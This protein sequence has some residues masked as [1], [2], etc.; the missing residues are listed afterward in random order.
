MLVSTTSTPS[1]L[2]AP[3]AS[4]VSKPDQINS[5][6]DLLLH[7]AETIPNTPLIAYPASEHSSSDLAEYTAKD[8]DAFV[9]EAAKEYTRLGLLPKESRSTA[10]EVVALLGPSNLDYVI[11]LLALSRMGF[12]VLFLST[13]LPTEAY[14]SLLQKTSCTKIVASP[15]FAS[16]IVE[17]I[18]G[19]GGY[20]ISSFPQ[21]DKSVYGRR[22]SSSARF[23]RRTEL[24][25]EE[26]CISFIVHSSGSTGL[27]KPIYQTHR[28]CLS[29]Y[30]LGSGMRAFVT[31]PLF[32]NHGLATTFRGIVSGK[33]TVLFNAN[34]PLTNAHLVDAMRAADAESFHCVPYALKVLAESEE[35]IEQLRRCRLVLFGGSSCPDELGD[36][37]V[38]RGVYIVGHYGATEMGQ[39]MT[40]FR[41]PESDKAWNYVR[42]LPKVAPYLRFVDIGAGVYECVVLD[43]LPSKVISNSDEPWPNC[44]RT[45]DTFVPHPTIPDAWK[46]LGR[47]DDRV[48]L[49]NGEKVLPIPYEHQIRQ[50]ELVQDALV[51]G[52]GRAFPGL[53]VIPSEKAAGMSKEEL[54]DALTPAIKTANARAEKFGQV[55]REMVEILPLGTDYPRTDKGTMI[56][57]ACYKKFDELI[58]SVYARF[59]SGEGIT[60]RKLDAEGLRT[61]LADLFA[62]RVGIAGLGLDT[63]FFDAGMDS[64]QSISARGHMQRELDLRGAVLGSNVVF[65]HPSIARLAAH[66]DALANGT[67]NTIDPE[68]AELDLM[69]DLVAKY[70]S[71]LPA[72]TPS[73]PLP[74]PDTDT[75]LLTG[76]TGSLGAH[77]L[78]QLLPQP[79]ITKIY[80]LVRAPS[81]DAAHARV[82]ASLQ[83]R[84]LSPDPALLAAKLVALP[85]D[86]SQPTLGLDAATYETLR[87]TLT[88]AIHSAW[89]V[90]FNLG[91][92][93]FAAQHV[94]GT[95]HLLRLC[96]SVPWARPARFAFVSSISAG[97][98]TPIPAVVREAL[99][100]RPEHAQGMGYARSK[101]V[102]EHVVGA[103]A[104]AGASSGIRVL[105]TGQ[106]VGDSVHGVWNETEAIPLMVR[107]ARGIG[108]LPRLDESPA[109]LPVDACAEAVVELSRAGVAFKEWVE[110]SET[111]GDGL[112][113]HV[114]NSKTFRWTEDLLP[115][116]RA[117]GLEFEEVGQREWVQRLRDGEQDPKKNPTVKLV[118]FFAEKYDN[119]RPGRKGLV[120]ATEKTA[121]KSRVIREGVDVIGEGVVDKC[122]KEWL[123]SW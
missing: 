92:S 29:N 110:Q 51:F 30:A 19:E 11:T 34:L 27:P 6:N 44:F 97:A 102:T 117:A 67:S 74:A 75:V 121:E 79:H 86:L 98:G 99:V 116:L 40:S 46:Y 57:A 23:Q 101:W 39:L 14:V 12:A 77:I 89:A 42:P 3:N 103:A 71:S 21:L 82:L 25:N 33:R 28:A 58:D 55:E 61:Y 73:N 62:N 24:V 111:E 76:A 120:F 2:D 16:T 113:F 47:L 123:K 17:D 122:V 100:E 83:T 60:K 114:Q 66:L 9:D 48:T 32:H 81:P 93:S 91:V 96:L 36:E 80:T 43:G 105:R 69:R 65:E 88:S 59:E 1:G 52:V 87:T 70:S 109:W 41:D 68:Q 106:I 45:R 15:R 4:K 38:R 35:G 115:A 7:K 118:D 37:L 18:R 22:P 94:A 119:D 112:V 63:D 10:S 56:R 108:A 64:L 20:P 90:N 50:H 5:I 31:L 104:K 84:H 53:L 13:R 8:L 72:F 95:T 85:A 26:Q 107:A 78:A 54:L 49:M